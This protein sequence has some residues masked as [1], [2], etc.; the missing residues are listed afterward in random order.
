[1]ASGFTLGNRIR[2][3][4]A[5]P[6]LDSLSFLFYPSFTAFRT[7][8]SGAHYRRAFVQGGR[9]IV[10]N[11][12]LI[13]RIFQMGDGAIREEVLMDVLNHQQL[14]R[15]AALLQAHREEPA[16]RVA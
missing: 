13:L 16:V 11:D 10:A 6:P 4:M 9:M 15:A 5:L 14:D 3:R 8:T 12:Y 1:M 2:T 7:V